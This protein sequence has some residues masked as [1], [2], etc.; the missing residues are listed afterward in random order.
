MN[1]QQTANNFTTLAPVTENPE[2]Y[3]YSNARYYSDMDVLMDIDFCNK[4]RL[5]CKPK[6]AQV[7]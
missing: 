6:R 1:K 7:V 3:L 5:G 2:G 4:F